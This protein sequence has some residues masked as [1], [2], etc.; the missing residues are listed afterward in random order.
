MKSILRIKGLIIIGSLLFVTQC[1]F[2][3]SVEGAEK[4]RTPD[5][6]DRLTEL[7]KLT[8]KEKIT[9][10]RDSNQNL[11]H[12][13]EILVSKL[14]S[15]DMEVK[16]YAAYLLGAYRFPQAADRLAKDIALE[17]KVRSREPRHSEWI[18]DLYPA[19][20]ALVKIG[21]PSIGAVIRNLEESDN[22]K[23]RD[24]SLKVI[25]HIEKR[26]K[27]IVELR[28]KKVL[29]AQKDSKR[30]ARLQSALEQL[31]DPKFPVN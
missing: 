24:L 27:D 22:A 14:G 3:P 5:V 9:L 23:I 18:W 17:D 25:Y 4:M 6:M 19:M 29:D 15:E 12:I 31:R 2:A 20:E 13:Q 7:E 1:P 8:E 11:H 16:F 10:V 30:K 21:N 28:L 26:D